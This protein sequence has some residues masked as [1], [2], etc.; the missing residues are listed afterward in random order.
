MKPAPKIQA[1]LSL[2]HLGE[3][4]TWEHHLF[5]ALRAHYAP[6]ELSGL[7]EDLVGLRTVG[8]L[9]VVDQRM[10]RGHILRRYALK[11]SARKMV[12]HQ[13]DLGRYLP[14][15]LDALVEAGE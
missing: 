6:A 4:G 10:H 12:E 11:A 9:E 3:R 7:R 15:Q 8:W 2:Y 1:V 14:L 5:G 13:L